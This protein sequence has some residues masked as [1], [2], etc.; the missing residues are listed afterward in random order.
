MSGAIESGSVEVLSP[1][2]CSLLL[3][4]YR[5]GERGDESHLAGFMLQPG[6]L[7]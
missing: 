5:D 4:Q 1:A 6:E 2:T 7:A 3:L